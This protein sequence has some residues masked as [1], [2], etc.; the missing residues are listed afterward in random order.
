MASKIGT[1]DTLQWLIMTTASTGD[2]FESNINWTS[3]NNM[4]GGRPSY[5]VFYT[6]D[7]NGDGKSDMGMAS[8]IGT[9]NTLQ[10]MM[11]VTASTGDRFSSHTNWTSVNNVWG[12]RPTYFTIENYQKIR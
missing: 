2:K 5:L 7:F 4:W 11:M 1:T 3:I 9:S 10:W 6:G 12:G 8:E